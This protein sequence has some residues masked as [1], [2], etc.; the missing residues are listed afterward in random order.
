MHKILK[1]LVNEFISNLKEHFKRVKNIHVRQDTS[2]TDRDTREPQQI[3]TG[4]G[5][6]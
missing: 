6:L 5:H 4:V 1:D 3:I 2:G